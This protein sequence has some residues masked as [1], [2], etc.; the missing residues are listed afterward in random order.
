MIIDILRAWKDPEYRKTL[1]PTELASVPEN[2]AGD[3]ELGPEELEGVAGGYHDSIGTCAKTCVCTI[4]C[5]VVPVG[6]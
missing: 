6:K 1:T 5:K 4:V 2:P 3:A